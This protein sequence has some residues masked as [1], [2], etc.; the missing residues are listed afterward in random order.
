M[1]ELLRRPRQRRRAL[2][3]A[4]SVAAI[5]LVLSACG[6]GGGN[7]GGAN[8]AEGDGGEAAELTCA[9][10]ATADGQFKAAEPTE[11]G[12]LWTDWPEMPVKDSWELFDE[13]EARTNV[14]LVPTH[15]PFSDRVEKQSLLISAGDAPPLIPLIYTGDEKQFAASQA[16]LPLS[17]Y[18]DYMPNFNKY[19]DEWDL[20]EMLNNLRQEDGKYYMTPGLQEVSVPM[21]SLIIRKDIFDEV[22]AQVPQTWDELRTALEKIKAAYPDS[23]PLGDGFEGAAMLNYAAHGFGTVAGWGFGNGTFQNP[24]TGEFEYAATSEGYKEMVEFFAGLAADGLLDIESFTQSN[25]GAGTVK[26]KVA[27]SQIFVASGAPGTV[28]EFKIA[29]AAVPGAEGAE[30]IQ[31]APPGGPAGNVVEPRGFWNGFMLTSQVKDDP[32]L[33]TYLQFADWLY[34]NP[35]AREMLQWGVEGETYTRTDDGVFT[36]LPEFKL[37][38]QNLNMDTGTI[39]IGKDLGWANNVLA[40]STES[41]ELKESYNTPEFVEYM[42]SVLADRQPRD[43]FSPAP[44][45]EMELEQASLISTALKDSVD[46]ATLQFIVGQRDL[47]EWDAYVAE[48]EGQN[49]QTYLDLINGAAD[50]YAEAVSKS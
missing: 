48:L 31:I 49:L 1:S 8:N 4:G 7:N 45:N 28:N 44:L 14:K 27:N 20:R 6:G 12:I 21:F 37:E 18:S 47:S 2:S 32:N 10:E 15:V 43:P 24:E 16:V 23:Y 26:E 17:D 9:Q 36:L 42:D 29:A 3:A 40:G 13:I 33:C 41:R 46:T 34:Y 39:D 38:A 25:D 11:L 35:E 22:G 30:F 50:R 19:V 5:A